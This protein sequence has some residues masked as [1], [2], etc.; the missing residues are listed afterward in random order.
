MYIKASWLGVITPVPKA[1]IT[2]APTSEC[3][4]S[5]SA[6]SVNLGVKNTG[7]EGVIQV[8]GT[9]DKGFTISKD[10]QSYT[11]GETKDIS[12]TLTG[13]SNTT[14]TN[15]TCT[16]TSSALTQSVSKQV[17][18]CVTGIPTCEQTEPWCESG[19]MFYC[20]TPFS[21]D[22]IKE[23]CLAKGQVCE[24]DENGVANCV[25]NKA[26]VCGDGICNGK[27]TFASCPVDC[28]NNLKCDEKT[29]K[30]LGWTEVTTEKQTIWSTIGIAKPKVNNWCKPTNA[31]YI[32]GG[33][34]ALILGLS[35]LF[36]IPKKKT[37]GKASKYGKIGK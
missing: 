27:E 30:F 23:D 7:E 36:I 6:G 11:S 22:T 2:T 9:C 19:N 17:N 24:L 15:G 20:P 25:S 13:S 21:P 33:V 31:P 5:G 29:P 4:V 37:K 28:T 10:S 18:V 16:I 1:S 8:T 34:L 26:P 3:F 12:L 14:T 32:V 35:A